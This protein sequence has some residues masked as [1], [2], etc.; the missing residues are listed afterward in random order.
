MPFESDRGGCQNGGSSTATFGSVCL[1]R[2]FPFFL[3]P[4]H[5]RL[6]I[7]HVFTRHNPSVRP[8][9]FPSLATVDFNSFLSLDSVVKTVPITKPIGLGNSRLSPSTSLS[10]HFPF[11]L[12]PHSGQAQ[13]I[14]LKTLTPLTWKRSF[15]GWTTVLWT[16]ASSTRAYPGPKPFKRSPSGTSTKAGRSFL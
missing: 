11:F 10:P 12:P 1:A 9:I 3:L 4:I 6:E 15:Q 5:C 8:N 7:P 16:K 2:V 13:S 14:T